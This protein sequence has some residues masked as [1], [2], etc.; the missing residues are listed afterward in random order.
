MKVHDERLRLERDIGRRIPKPWQQNRLL[1][2]ESDCRGWTTK[3]T[4][5]HVNL[6]G[7]DGLQSRDGLQQRGFF[8]NHSHPTEQ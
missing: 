8:R 6:A 2:N 1:K 3:R 5:L 4:A 7:I